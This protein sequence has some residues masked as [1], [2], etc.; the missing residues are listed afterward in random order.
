M[1]TLEEEQINEITHLIN[2]KYG[3]DFAEYAVSSFRRRVQRVLELYKLKDVETL[4]AKLS[5]ENFF[6][7]FISEITVNVTEMFRD[8]GC[9]VALRDQVI[10]NIIKTSDDVRIWHAGCSSGEEVFSMVI[11]LDGMG[12]LDKVKIIASDI[13]NV[14]LQK[15]MKNVISEKNM[16]VNRR[17]YET[18]EGVGELDEYF[19]AIGPGY[20]LKEEY[21]LQIDFVEHDLV[22]GE[23]FEQIDLALCRN[24]MIYFN[25]SLQNKV[26]GKIHQ[27]L[28]KYSYLAIGSKES[29]IWCEVAHK[30]IVTNNEE[31]VY[32]K[33]KD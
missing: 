11:L 27:A 32:K 13:D 24:V 20:T 25:Q 31:K 22:K 6:K 30:F 28:K 21:L 15:A 8:P 5:N 14:I 12:I 29:L 33:I 3:Y 4:L 19:D 1:E 2:A 9:W 7:D 18:F 10:P 23:P 16:E 26:L 17:N